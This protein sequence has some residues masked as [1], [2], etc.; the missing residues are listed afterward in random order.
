MS[1]ETKKILL[2]EDN[3]GDARLILIY[4]NKETNQSYDVVVA[5]TLSE[6]LTILD[7]HNFDIVI[8]DLALPNSQG[9]NTFQQIHEAHT[10]IPIIVLTGLNDKQKA[11][12]AIQAGAQDYLVKGELQPEIISRS[13]SYSIERKRA[14][15][16]IRREREKAQHYLDIAGVILLVLDND[17]K[18]EMINQNGCDVLG[19]SEDEI[20]GKDWIETF[21]PKR[22][23]GEISRIHKGVLS[24]EG[25]KYRRFEN[26]IVTKEGEERIISWR[27]TSVHDGTGKVI[28]TLS[29]GEDI[30]DRKQAEAAIRESEERLRQIT[31]TL[32]DTSWITDWET[33]EI[34]FV[35]PSY[36]DIWGRS[37]K[38]LYHDK[39]NWSD[40]IHPDDRS[41]V[42]DK[43]VNLKSDGVFDEEYRI[44]RPDGVIR[45]IRDRGYPV[46]N[47]SSKVYRVAG[48]AQDITEKK[49]HDREMETIANVSLALRSVSSRD[50]MLPII[51]EQI[52]NILNADGAA[53][54]SINPNSNHYEIMAGCGIW[55]DLNEVEI[56]PNG[57]TSQVI[58][59]REA[60]VNNQAISLPD[61]PKIKTDFIG[62]ANAVAC[63]PLIAQE[64]IIGALWIGRKK[65]ITDESILLLNSIANISANAIQRATL[66]E[67]TVR[68]L[69]RLEA[70]HNIDTAINANLDLNITLN[71]LID[72]VI[73][74]L[75][76]DATS[77]FLFDERTL[78]LAYAAGKGFNSTN[79]LVNVISVPASSLAGKVIFESRMI[80]ALNLDECKVSP[81]YSNFLT[82]ENF[83]SYV[84]VPLIAKSRIVGVLELYTHSPLYPKDDWM[85]FLETLAGQAAIAINNANLYH[86]L[87]RSIEELRQ[88]YEQTIEGWALT[89]EMRDD[90]TRGHSQRVT[91]MT[92]II[93]KKMG[94]KDDELIHIRRGAI[95]HDIGKMAI[96]DEIL[97]KPGPLT[98]SE[99]D[100]MKRHPTLAVEWLSKISFLQ[101]ALIIPQYHHERWDGT[102]YPE[103]LI[104]EEI[105]LP[106]RIFA[107][108]D[109][110]DA[111]L[112]DRP[113]RKAWSEQKTLAH[114]QDQSGKHFDPEIVKIFFELVD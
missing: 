19:Y 96:P 37:I 49:Q 77:L 73:S 47:E 79:E 88:G 65:P 52:T 25:G 109:V 53:Y 82:H 30:T 84:G 55:A 5:R 72:Q 61:P 16:K 97:H 85:D 24:K 8:M 81:E 27:N 9:L 14:E 28:G 26:P 48:I 99:W 6:S 11:I 76:V 54:I 45:W 103:G 87:Q 3:P 80:K 83:V 7:D 58:E 51:F 42:W 92:S 40:A 113:Y 111:L 114:I 15:K 112:S 89:L 107:I 20:I 34:L 104:G 100:L 56:Y 70:L 29:S 67:K 21:I 86:E 64:E 41:K 12:E 57:I 105:P 36:E 101:Q 69:K 95:L 66:H 44:I 10:D 102:G 35:S 106:G 68:S 38:D 63:I 108:V 93:A 18:I 60:F 75:E 39:K 13:I 71:V 1:D 98:D 23:Q 33:H 43:F 74:Q 31:D 17:G 2:V 90:E 50:E 32:E 59:S 62:R 46:L 22:L 78:T 91:E 94:I 110:W 4:L